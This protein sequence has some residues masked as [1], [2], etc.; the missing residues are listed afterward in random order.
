MI[1]KLSEFLALK[2]IQRHKYQKIKTNEPN[3]KVIFGFIYEIMQTFNIFGFFSFRRIYSFF[4][5]F[6]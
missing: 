5:Q 3:V 4:L 6:G 1:F 2:F